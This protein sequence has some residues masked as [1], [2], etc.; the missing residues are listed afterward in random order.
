M[1]AGGYACHGIPWNEV[2]KWQLKLSGQ[3][4]FA[5]LWLHGSDEK[6]HETFEKWKHL[7]YLEWLGNNW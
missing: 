5:M 4:Y 7:T 1:E 2:P 3:T 6:C